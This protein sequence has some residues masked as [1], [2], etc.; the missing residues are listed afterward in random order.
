M[1]SAHVHTFD[2]DT[3]RQTAK[4]MR[5]RGE[6]VHD[7]GKRYRDEHGK[8][9]PNVDIMNSPPRVSRNAMVPGDE[10]GTS[11]LRNGPSLPVLLGF[12]GTA[13]TAFWVKEFFKGAERQFGL[14]EGLRSRYNTQIASAVVQDVY[15]VRHDGLPVVEVTQFESDERSADQVRLLQPASKGNDTAAEDYEYFLAYSTLV[16]ADIWGYYGLKGYLTLTLDEVGKDGISL[17]G[18][19]RYLGQSVD[20]PEMSTAELC[21]ELLK[22]WHLFILQVPSCGHSML[23]RTYDYWCDAAGRNRVIP[24]SRPEMLAEVRAALIYMTEV[25]NP[26]KQGL[27]DF[28][29]MDKDGSDAIRVDSAT[30]DAVWDMIKGVGELV[31]AQAALPNY[32]GIPLPGSVFRHY[33]DPWPIDF[34]REAKNNEVNPARND[35]DDDE[36]PPRGMTAGTHK[37][38]E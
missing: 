12:D 10:P 36:V 4:T 2:A 31:G 8:L 24:V 35:S 1:K 19:R 26:T 17:E 27:I 14:L 21:H 6:D 16:E 37:S 38:K 5:A 20:M 22:R 25:G 13:S 3:F 32:D 29:R 7:A 9:H 28:F 23:S 11:V 18:V 34:G 30:I 33:R 15:N